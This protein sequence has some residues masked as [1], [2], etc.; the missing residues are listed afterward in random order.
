[1]KRIIKLVAALLVVAVTFSN[2]GATAYAYYVTPGEF[3][4]VKYTPTYYFE[5]AKVPEISETLIDS[6]Y[7]RTGEQINLHYK[8]VNGNISLGNVIAAYRWYKSPAYKNDLNSRLRGTPDKL[9]NII[10][11][12]DAKGAPLCGTKYPI[13]GELQSNGDY[14][15]RVGD[16]QMFRY[17]DITNCRK[18]ERIR[19]G[20]IRY[21]IDYVIPDFC[22]MDGYEVKLGTYE[23]L[24]SSEYSRKFYNYFLTDNPKNPDMWTYTEGNVVI[25]VPADAKGKVDLTFNGMKVSTF[26]LGVTR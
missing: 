11:F 25:D 23:P 26:R 16:N 3:K 5:T 1:M 24:A 14:L 7:E 12:L 4:S 8:H 19:P 2:M 18:N 22:V 13:Y 15:F 20:Y 9:P 17:V 6:T 21:T 10:Q